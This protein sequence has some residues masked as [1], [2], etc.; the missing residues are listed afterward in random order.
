MVM[1]NDIEVFIVVT[2]IGSSNYS[3]T[4]RLRGIVEDGVDI[5]QYLIF[6]PEET[7]KEVSIPL[8]DDLVALEEPTQY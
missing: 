7:A 8:V 3:R 2:K 4:V 5:T 1:E 6:S